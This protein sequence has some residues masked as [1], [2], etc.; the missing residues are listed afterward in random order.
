MG[1]EPGYISHMDTLTNFRNR[2]RPRLS[3]WAAYE[4]WQASGSLD[5][6][7]RANRQY[8][9]ILE[10]TPQSLIDPQVDNAL[11]AYIRNTA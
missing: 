6:A 3:E 9:E 2:W 8:K 11:Q 5:V 4:D 1:H 7:A 10:T